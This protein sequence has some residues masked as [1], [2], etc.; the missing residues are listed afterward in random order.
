M[1]LTRLAL[2]NPVAAAV[3]V[4]LVLLFGSIALT[5]IPVQMIPTVVLPRITIN[6]GWRAAAP[7]EVES[8]IIE[9]QE[10]VLRGVPGVDQMVSTATQGMGTVA[11]TFDVGVPRSAPSSKS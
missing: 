8:E 11:L 2:G 1:T 4:L 9:V 7:D 10:D 6:T 3:A 5:Q